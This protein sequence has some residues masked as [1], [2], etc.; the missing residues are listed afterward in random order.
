[1]SIPKEPR[2]QMINIMYLVLTAMLALNVSAEIL[3]AFEMIDDSL[4]ISNNAMS[5]KMSDGQKAFASAIEK[6]KFGAAYQPMVDEA[7][8][9]GDKTIAYIDNLVADLIAKSNGEGY[10]AAETGKKL[11]SNRDKGTITEELITNGKGI[12]LK[13][14]L[15]NTRQTMLGLFDVNKFA[16]NGDT[17]FKASDVASFK[18]AMPM[19]DLSGEFTDDHGKPVPWERKM[20]YQM[21]I[22][23]ALTLLNKMKNDVVATQAMA[24]EKLLGKVGED[25]LLFDNYLVGVVPNG[26]KFITGEE[27]EADIFLAASH[28]K[29]ITL[30]AMVKSRI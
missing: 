21:P 14:L 24:V 12:E 23:P 22:A 3:N 20:F 6:N 2:Q 1:M 10:D 7:V 30:I 27:Y 19:Q 28:M 25:E 11:K 8:E 18:Q 15:Q 29:S 9:S 5:K 17:L 26:K 13:D 16:E 4:N